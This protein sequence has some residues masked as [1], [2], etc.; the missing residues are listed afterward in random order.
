MGPQRSRSRQ[1]QQCSP[2]P[3]HLH[4][5]L[6][7]SR[8]G[9]EASRGPWCWRESHPPFPRQ[10]SWNVWVVTLVQAYTFHKVAI[11]TSV[12]FLSSCFKLN[13]NYIKT[14][15]KDKNHRI[16][17]IL[18]NPF[19]H[20]FGSDKGPSLILPAGGDPTG[21]GG[22]SRRRVTAGV[23]GATLMPRW[24]HLE[25]LTLLCKVGTGTEALD[26]CPERA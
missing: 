3:S 1:G 9:A 22:G 17:R 21:A 14:H 6:P 24:L 13:W 23:S 11:I 5:H 15:L 19:L 8:R 25:P 10:T 16:Y 2:H 12:G 4:A 26:G 7:H 18:E 20:S